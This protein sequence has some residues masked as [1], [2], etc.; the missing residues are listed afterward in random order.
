LISGP[1]IRACMERYA[2]DYDA[3]IRALIDAANHAGGKDNITVVVIAGPEYEI[4]AEKPPAARMAGK[5]R[6]AWR[7][8]AIASACGLL[9]VALGLLYPWARAQFSSPGPRTLV[10]GPAGI[11]AALSQAHPGDTVVIPQGKYTERILLREG[12]TLRAQQPANVTLAS[13]DG[14]PAVVAHKIETGSIEGVWIQGDL[15]APAS[16]GIQIEDAS[17]AISNV[18]VTGMQ[19]GIEVRGASAPHI[20]SSQIENN[21]GAGIDVEGNAKPNIENNLIAANGNG[22]PGVAKPGV[23]VGAAARPVFKDNGIVNNAAD[24]I[25]VHGHGYQPADFEEN[26]FGELSPKRAVRLIDEPFDIEKPG[27]EKKGKARPP[28]K[29]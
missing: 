12:V 16:A 23:E 9:G 27:G 1:E 11:N 3:A 29:P 20:T 21:L 13:P 5:S 28:V 14:G 6:A 8:V 2:P 4:P 19:T 24:P 25:W 15:Q 22:K 26:F 18:R 17:P 10:A 7:P